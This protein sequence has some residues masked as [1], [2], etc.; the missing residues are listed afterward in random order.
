[1][2][3]VIYCLHALSTHLFKLGK[4]PLI[5]DLCGKVNF[6]G[7]VQHTYLNNIFITYFQLCTVHHELYKVRNASNYCIVFELHFCCKVAR[8]RWKKELIL[9]LSLYWDLSSGI[10]TWKWW[11]SVSAYAAFSYFVN[12]WMIGLVLPLSSFSLISF[13]YYFFLLP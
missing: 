11:I 5:Q 8:E 9:D 7:I 2:P 13:F 12:D 6:T 3:R 1:M 10:V 4:G